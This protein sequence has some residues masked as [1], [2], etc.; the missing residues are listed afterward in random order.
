VVGSRSGTDKRLPQQARAWD[1]RARLLAAAREAFGARGHNQ[2][3]LTEHILKPAGVSVGSFYLQFHDKTDLLIAVIDEAAEQR[4]ARVISAPDGEAELSLE[5]AMSAVV[6]GFFASLDSD[7]DLWHIQLRE[8]ANPDPKI[9][10]RI[11]AGRR[12]WTQQLARV[13]RQ[14]TK[15]S[16]DASERGAAML[17]SFATG[18]AATYLD[19]SLRE[20]KRRRAAMIDD[21]TN[22]ALSGL[23]HFIAD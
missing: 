2:V 17:V 18:L 11:L 7:D 1:T 15:A 12:R 21:A 23:K 16:S 22:F 19:L 6:R 9:K 3:N 4:F 13:I 10:E 8:R 5:A 14:S 20:R